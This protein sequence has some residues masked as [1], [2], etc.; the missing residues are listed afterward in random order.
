MLARWRAGFTLIAICVLALL[1]RLPSLA[2]RSLWYDEAFAV[3]FAEQGLSAMLVGTLAPVEGGASDIHP[4]LYYV[5]LNA[6]MRLFGQ[7]VAL[8]R[9]WGV[10][11]GVASIGALYAVLEP[12]LGRKVA[13]WGALIAALAPFHVHYSQEA[14]MY[15]LLAFLL[16]SATACY[17]R[18]ERAIGRRVW[19]WWGAFGVCAG[20]AMY[21][22]QLA[23]FYLLALALLPVV[24]RRTETLKGVGLGGL[25]ALVIYAPWLVNIPAQFAKVQAYYW[26][27]RP[28]LSDLFQSNFLFVSIYAELPPT[29]LL[30]S[31]A[32]ATVLVLLALAML[33]LILRQP[34]YYVMRSGVFML[35]WL[36][37]VPM[38]LMWLVS[39]IQPV[40]L[41]RGLIASSMML[42]GF[43]AWAVAVAP[44]LFRAL[45]LGCGVIL[46]VLGLGTQYRLNSFPYSPISNLVAQVR[47]DWQAGDRLIHFNKLSAL[48]ARFYGRELDQYYLADPLG[49]PE[50]TLAGPTQAVLK[51]LASADIASAVGEADRVWLVMYARAESQYAASGRPEWREAQAWLAQN[52]YQRLET[53]SFNDVNLYL[54]QR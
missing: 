19:L 42:Y 29:E 34:R 43:L 4:L 36:W 24:Q 8:I 39:Q 38:V 53:R 22:Q 23:A 7:E 25:I 52:G 50:D 12:L 41:D 45:M 21:T 31:L 44:R 54:Y 18:A 9:L 10:L 33:G 17:V 3:L 32:L 47:M 30:L 27:A 49:A 28:D 51:F 5:T 1:V 48:P 2:E 35:A 6:W 13:L 11:F 14:R 15:G 16:M 46:V 37:L 26:V 40:Y 20:L